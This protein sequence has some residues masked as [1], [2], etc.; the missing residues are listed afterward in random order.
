MAKSKESMYRKALDRLV[1]KTP[2]VL[3]V[4]DYGISNDA[5][6]IEAGSG[7][8]AIKIARYPKLVV[9]I[10]LAAEAWGKN[11]LS[12]VNKEKA[13]KEKTKREKGILQSRFEASLKREQELAI[14]LGEL[15]KEIIA[16]KSKVVPFIKKT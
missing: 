15:E 10:G 8:G 7:R 2:E 12:P 4:G 11:N 14:R 5:V 6:A 1:S 13:Q 16:L 3:T 9:A